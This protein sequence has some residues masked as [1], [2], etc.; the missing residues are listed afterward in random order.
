MEKYKYKALNASGRPIRGVLSASNENDLFNQLQSAGLELVNCTV[1]SKKTTK[2][3]AFG[4]ITIR[5][6]IQF[7]LHLDQM[8][9][10]GIPLL[11]ALSDI[12]DTTENDMIRDMMTEIYR[13]VSE[14][15]NLSEAM[16]KHPKVF[17]K[18]YVSLVAAGEETG[19]MRASYQQLIKYMKWLDEMQSTIRKATRYPMIL[20]VVVVLA[21]TV[22]MGFVVPEVVGFIKNMDFELPFATTSLIAT[23]DFFR[24]Y[25]W[26]VFATPVIFYVTFFALRR[27]STD[28][29]Y[30]MDKIMLSIPI[31]GILIQKIN[32]ARFCQ[33]FGAL[34]SA[35]LPILSCIK[36]GTNTVNNLVLTEALENIQNLIKTGSTLSQAFNGSGEF[37]SMVVRMLKVGEESGNLTVVLD[38]VADF[39][40][41]DVDEE[42]QKL[43]AMIEP[44]LTMVL[45]VIIIWIAAGVFGPIYSNLGK[46]EF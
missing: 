25:W 33:T 46:M 24:N 8:E 44:A 16:A 9:V 7:F 12:R 11:D 31:M 6:L 22:M 1:L 42:V 34:Y 43:V 39:Y 10:S 41:K 17:L 18:L 2:S 30:Q 38:Q 13:D 3:R 29:A 36:S 40:T 27:A 4:K 20:G 26:A 32:I 14:G 35:G 45:G 23:S 21:I 15:A 37:P 28:F 19:R 5:D